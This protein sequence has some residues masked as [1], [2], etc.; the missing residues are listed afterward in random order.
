MDSLWQ[1]A[2][3]AVTQIFSVAAALGVWGWVT[4]IG[5]IWVGLSLTD[6]LKG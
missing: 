1:G 4:V 3:A 2:V 5:L 6:K